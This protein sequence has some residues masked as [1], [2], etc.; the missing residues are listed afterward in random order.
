MQRNNFMS[1]AL[2]LRSSIFKI[3]LALSVVGC[4]TPGT[5]SLSESVEAELVAM[6]AVAPPAPTALRSE[7]PSPAAGLDGLPP[8][9]MIIRGT[10]RMI[11]ARPSAPGAVLDGGDVSLNF[12]QAP[13]SDVAHAV[14]GDIL[15]VPYV[16][17][18][19]VTGTLTINTQSPLPRDRIFPVFEAALQA[20]GLALARDGSGVYHVGRPEA[21]RNIAPGLGPIKGGAPG[22]T[23][24]VV[25][26][27][28][29]AASEMSEILRPVAGP[30]SLVRIDGYRNLLMLAG[31]RNQIEGWMDIVQTFDVD[32]L[33]GMSVGLFPLR[34]ASVREVEVALSTLFGAT[35]GGPAVAPT[36]EQMDGSQ[37]APVRIAMPGVLGSVVRVLAIERMNAILVISPRAHYVDQARDWIA[38]FDTPSETAYESNLYVYP[39]QNGTATHLASLLSA[40]FGGQAPAGQ[41]AQANSGVAPGLGRTL[42]GGT[43]AMSSS[44]SG[45]SSGSGAGLRVGG[46]T[47]ESGQGP[48][49]S[50]VELSPGVRVVADEYNNAL[51]V[52][53]PRSEYRKIEAALIQLDKSPTQVLI[54]ASIIEVTLRDELQYGLQWFFQGGVGSNHTGEGALSRGAFNPFVPRGATGTPGPAAEGFTY[55]I[56]NSAAQ[57]RVVLNVLAKK[58]L[59]NVLS[60][61]SVMVLDNHTAHIQ[62]GDQQPIR[63]STSITDGGVS[64]TSIEYK[65]TGVL[66][67]VTPSVNAG[68]MVTMAIEQE[69]TDVGE[70]DAA[71]E[72]RTFLQRRIGSKVSVRSG[73]SVVLGG[74]IRDNTV[75]ARS[76]LPVLHDLPLVGNLFGA[77]NNQTVRTELLVMLT[78]RVM[79]NDAELRQVGEEM[80]NRMLTLKGV[81]DRRGTAYDQTPPAL[82]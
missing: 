34:H 33:S 1:T 45:A 75:R 53:A 13:I 4:A 41:P 64:T 71:T 63:S 30:E 66:L 74:L 70:I 8:V 12:E 55:S 47:A 17:N 62:V 79:Q 32:I 20:N 15:N 43:G 50:Q 18:Q 14:L 58:S 19:S 39:V 77:T 80:R 72:Q 52:Y 16:I 2:R 76:G 51:L 56:L 82:Q 29:I 67:T 23:L 7:T 36:A 3:G 31:N 40:V 26:L 21:L 22:Q 49:I 28:Y 73:E 61:P 24:V 78:P 81:M 35:D 48:E 27:Q 5:Q 57:I 69:V 37:Q 10:D 11:R 44:L 9:P 38:R 25:P 65:D 54:E 68:A 46:A 59:L 60:S 6:G 42:L